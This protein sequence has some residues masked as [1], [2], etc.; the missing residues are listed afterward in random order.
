MYRLRRPFIF[1]RPK[2]HSRQSHIKRSRL[3]TIAHALAARARQRGRNGQARTLALG[4]PNLG[5]GIHDTADEAHKDG[6]NAGE[7]DGRVEEDEAREGN[8]ELVKGT[9]WG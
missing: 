1:T 9:C 4:L 7:S 3:E 5:H 2:Q 6:A 8:W